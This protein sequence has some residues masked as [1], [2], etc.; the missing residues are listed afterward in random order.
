MI[1]G[2]EKN[3]V[4]FLKTKFKALKYFA[5]TWD[6]FEK[7]PKLGKFWMIHILEYFVKISRS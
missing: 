5:V 1:G 6:C 3:E 2:R 7:T 4:L